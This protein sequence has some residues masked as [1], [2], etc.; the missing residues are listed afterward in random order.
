MKEKSDRILFEYFWSILIK[1]G[2]SNFCAMCHDRRSR[3]PTE[4]E[5]RDA[6]WNFTRD[7]NGISDKLDDSNVARAGDFSVY[8]QPRTS[9]LSSRRNWSVE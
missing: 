2:N 5:Q 7:T 8:R 4:E 3:F 1:F 9:F 6:K